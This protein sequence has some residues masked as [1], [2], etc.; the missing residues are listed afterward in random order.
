MG[1]PTGKPKTG[2]RTKG[3]PNKLT[4]D[5]KD[6]ILTA[7]DKAGGVNYLVA[8]AAD[9]PAAFLTL[10]GKVLPLQVTGANGKDLIPPPASGTDWL[11]YPIPPKSDGDE[12]V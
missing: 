2:G 6:M 12:P 4:S 3:T 11:G 1:R 7:L 9:S 5:V 8:R 10:V